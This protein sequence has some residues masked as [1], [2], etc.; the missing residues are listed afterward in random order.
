MK[1]VFF[2]LEVTE[3]GHREDPDICEYEK[4]NTQP[5]CCIWVSGTESAMSPEDESVESVVEEKDNG[6][7]DNVFVR[8]D[9]ETFIILDFLLEVS[10]IRIDLFLC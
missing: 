10:K 1:S 5:L 2:V 3:E 8:V 9:I 4:A 7:Y 6:N